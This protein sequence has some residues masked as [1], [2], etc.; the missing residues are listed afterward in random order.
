MHGRIP[1][2]AI[3]SDAGMERIGRYALTALLCVAIVAVACIVYRSGSPGGNRHTETR[4]IIPSCYSK[5]FSFRSDLASGLILNWK[6]KSMIVFRLKPF[7]GCLSVNR[8]KIIQ[9]FSGFIPVLALT[10]WNAFITNS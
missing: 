5:R 1:I 7:S 3:L 2:R 8:P 10:N 6:I 4:P 9:L